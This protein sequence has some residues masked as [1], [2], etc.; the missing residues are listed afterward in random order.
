MTINLYTRLSAA[1]F[2]LLLCGSCRKTLGPCTGNCEVV[3]FSGIAVDPGSQK[4]LAGLEVTVSMHK[5]QNCTFCNEDLVVI[6][7]KT[8]QD[9]TFALSRSVDTTQVGNHSCSITVQG[10]GNYL[11]SPQ[12]TGP[13]I[14]ADPDSHS[15][16]QFLTID[17][18]GAASYSEF[19]FYQ[20][21]AMTVQLHRTSPILASE[22]FV[23]LEFSIGGGGASYFDLNEF[24]SNA[25]TTLT[26]NTGANIFTRIY[27]I[28]YVTDSTKGVITDSIRCVTGGNNTIQVSY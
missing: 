17:S 3:Y 13:G 5:V 21:V 8:K 12:P 28:Q 22:P 11:I 24:P 27:A 23:A 9:G 15:R 4:P 14:V 6:S 18:T 1:V 7:G 26:V 20:P 16:G 19:D 10:P 2:V 25:D